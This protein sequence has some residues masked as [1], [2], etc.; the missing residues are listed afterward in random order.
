M[1]IIR[2]GRSGLS[3]AP[4]AICRVAVWLSWQ[5]PPVLLR[6]GL[7]GEAA[8]IRTT[9]F[10]KTRRGEQRT[11]VGISES[12]CSMLL[13]LSLDLLVRRCAFDAAAALAQAV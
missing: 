5:A 6:R 4:R 9:K 13:R 8:A 1:S 12:I 11:V 7:G 10:E 3:Y 2:R